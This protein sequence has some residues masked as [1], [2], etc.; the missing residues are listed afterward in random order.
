MVMAGWSWTPIRR[1]LPG[2]EQQLSD[3]GRRIETLW[4]PHELTGQEKDQ[5]MP[6]VTSIAGPSRDAGGLAAVG[7]LLKA[8]LWEVLAIIGVVQI[9]ILPVIAASTE[10][11]RSR[12]SR[13]RWCTC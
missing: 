7:M 4:P 1:S 11:E 13:V 12:G 10:S 2:Q 5:L 6:A 9:L 3:L 8:N